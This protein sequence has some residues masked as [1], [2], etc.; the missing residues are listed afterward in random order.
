MTAADAPTSWLGREVPPQ[1]GYFAKAC[2]ERIQ[3]DVL[4]PCEPLPVTP[5]F[6]ML[7]DAAI[8]FEVG[9]FEHL[10]A[11]VAGA[12]RFD[13]LQPRREREHLTAQAMRGGAP[14]I[15]GGR[16]PTDQAGQRVGEPDLLV[17]LGD[18]LKTDG[19]WAYAAADVKN[20]H[21]VR[22][23]VDHGAELPMAAAPDWSGPGWPPVAASIQWRYADLMQLAHY[24]RMLEACGHQAEG[25]CWAGIIGSEEQLAWYDLDTPS[26]KASAY[27]DDPPA[28]QL[29]SLA[30][31]DIEFAHRLAVMAAAMHKDDPATTLL[32][33]PILIDAC[34]NCPWRGR[35]FEAVERTADLSLLM[36]P[37][38]R[39]QHHDRGVT[40]LRLL[41]SLDHRTALLVSKRVDV[42]YLTE[43]LPDHGPAT[44]IAE[45]IPG[46]PKQI[47]RLARA[48]V[49]T[50]GDV[51]GLCPRTLRYEGA[52]MVDLPMQIDRACACRRAARLPSAQRV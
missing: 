40:D 47:E 36:S 5:F 16:L 25:G 10:H 2:P 8:H 37:A 23:P 9:V 7:G 50:M 48:G 26:W 19:N 17:R 21:V 15:L 42:T 24:Q 28:G 46:R 3:L 43:R 33:V 20:H 29:S 41:A 35:C 30:V 49:R 18:T 14:L 22:R 12:V 6:A 44:A 52:G 32:A 4:R 45:V 31:Y 1:G 39:R 38:K 27:I 11:S 51:E 34:S 13:H